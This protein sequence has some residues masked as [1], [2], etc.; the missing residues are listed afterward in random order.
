MKT[1]I[2]T[3]KTN[4]LITSVEA[5]REDLIFISCEP[6]HLIEI[7]TDLRDWK[8][9]RHLVM[10][11]AVDWIEQGQ[12]QLTYLLYNYENHSDI[13]VKIRI[14]RENPEAQ[15]IHHLWKTAHIYQRELHEMFGIVFPG[16]P[17]LEESMLLEGWDQIPPMRKEFDTKKYSEETFFPRPGR[18]TS[19]PK[20]HMKQTNYPDD[21][22]MNDELKQLVRDN[23]KKNREVQD[24]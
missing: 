6:D 2:E 15:S 10:I 4:S 8:N 14:P 16:S 17:R 12:F 1:L 18:Q 20:A 13:G 5:K 21:A 3:L 19:D 11:S 23:R 22:K 24:A 7:L 9:F